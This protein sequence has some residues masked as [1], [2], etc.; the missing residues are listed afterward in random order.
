[1]NVIHLEVMLHHFY[2]PTPYPKD[3][4]AVRD[5]HND[6]FGHGLLVPNAE[7]SERGSPDKPRA[8]DVTERG[9]V[10]VLA[11]TNVPLPVQAW[12]MPQPKT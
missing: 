8:W 12:T 9:R 10:F 1:M 11:L 4:P 3:T 5:A 7:R 6:L 2:N